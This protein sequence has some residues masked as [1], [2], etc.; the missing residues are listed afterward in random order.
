MNP[1]AHPTLAAGRWRQFPLMMQLAHVGSEVSRACSA[2]TTGKHER[3]QNATERM[4]EL[5]DGTIAD[6][7]NRARLRELCRLREVLCDFFVGNNEWGSTEDAW[8][9]YFLHCAVAAKK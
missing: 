1:I 8:N 6:P 9:R 3:M 7:K 5:L 2:R 4:L